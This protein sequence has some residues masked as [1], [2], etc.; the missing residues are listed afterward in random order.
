M[1]YDFLRLRIV[2]PIVRA[3]LAFKVIGLERLDAPG[4][5]LVAGNHLSSG[6]TFPIPVVLRRRVY[7]LARRSLF[8]ATNPKGRFLAWILR[9]ACQVPM[10]TGGGP[11]AVESLN[12]LTGMLR[13]GQVVAI[14]PEGT[15][16]PDGRLYRF[17]TGVAR[18]ALAAGVPVFPLAC[19]NTRIRRG[20]LG[21]PSMRGATLTIGEPLHFDEYFGRQDDAAVVRYVTDRIAAT[22][23][24]MTG[25]TYVDVYAQ[26]VKSGELTSAQADAFVSD[27]L[28]AG[29]VPPPDRQAPGMAS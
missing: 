22:I 24:H 15:R 12:T 19:V 21:L 4:G 10:E 3:L 11:G 2:A 14:F 29:D 18:L 25:Q 1:F 27:R 13:D 16:S 23:Q 9:L 17:H 20:L 26:R 8:T 7:S 28:A 5:A 6:D